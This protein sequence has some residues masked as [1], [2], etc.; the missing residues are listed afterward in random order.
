LRGCQL[1][2]FEFY[3]CAV[4]DSSLVG[5]FG[6]GTDLA[7]RSFQVSRCV[8][9]GAGLGVLDAGL[10]AVLRFALARRLYGQPVAALPHA[11]ATL[12]GAFADLLTADALVTTA[13]R[14]L[15]LLPGSASV[16]AAAT[17]YLVPLLLEDAMNSL[18]VILGARFYLREGEYAGFGKHM[19]DLPPLGI[20]HAGGVSCQLT[21]LPQLPRRLRELGEPA[22]AAVFAASAPLPALGLT[23]LRQL[24]PAGDPLL[25]TLREN[26]ATLPGTGAVRTITAALDD[27]VTHA[28]G[29]PARDLGVQASPAALGVTERYSLLL[30]ATAATG[31]QRHNPEDTPWLQLAMS[32]LARRLTPSPAPPADEREAEDALLDDLVTRAEQGFGFCFDRDRVYRTLSH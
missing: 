1:G 8:M 10:F 4:A 15:H 30:A 20:G 14:A 3:D 31:Y 5:D 11:R 25:A 24:A 13:T 6:A 28:A 21:M 23:K 29:M 26:L 16:Y 9:A 12:A 19:R 18:S 32:R 27:L 7:L 22:P 17:K 2:G